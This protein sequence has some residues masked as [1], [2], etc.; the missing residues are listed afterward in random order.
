[1]TSYACVSAVASRLCFGVLR[2]FRYMEKGEISK[3]VLSKSDRI[4]FA[5]GEGTS[6]VWAFFATTLCAKA[7]TPCSDGNPK[8]AQAG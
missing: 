8:T 2:R 1:M 4:S 5:T 6:A 7:A 3:L